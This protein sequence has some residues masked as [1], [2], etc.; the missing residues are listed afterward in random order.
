MLDFSYYG[1]KFYIGDIPLDAD[2][3]LLYFDKTDNLPVICSYFS[4]INNDNEPITTYKILNGLNGNKLIY[5]STEA[6]IGTVRENSTTL[7]RLPCTTK[8]YDRNDYLSIL[9]T[10]CCFAVL[11]LWLTNLFTSIFKKRGLL[12]GLF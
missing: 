11:T 4:S 6:T 8:F 9:C 12:S 7:Y 5:N 3:V 10:F 2:K 1:D